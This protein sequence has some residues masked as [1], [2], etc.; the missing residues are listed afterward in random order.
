MSSI[1]GHALSDGPSEAHLNGPHGTC[2]PVGLLL[3][4]SHA[5]QEY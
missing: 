4:P 3:E 1:A 5:A 2:R